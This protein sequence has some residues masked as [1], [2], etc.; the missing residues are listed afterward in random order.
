MEREHIVRALEATNWVV[1][2]P[3][4]AAVRLGMKRTTLVYKMRKLAIKRS[5]TAA[6]EGPAKS[7]V[8]HG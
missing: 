6:H 2:G 7:H 3:N 1:A 5:S 4:G 8:A